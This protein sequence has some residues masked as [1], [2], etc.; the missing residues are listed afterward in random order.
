VAVEEKARERTGELQ[1]EQ[2][3]E[4]RRPGAIAVSADGEWIAFSVSAVC[5]SKGKRPESHIWTVEA[6]GTCRQAT[7][8]SGTDSLPSWSPDGTLAFASDREHAGR[9]SLYL[10]G[11]GPGEARP[12]GDVAGSVEDLSWSPDGRR[13]LVLAADLGADRAG[14]QAATKIQEAGAG[15]DDPKVKRP[16]ES[17]RRLYMVDAETGATEEVGPQGVHVFEVDWD[18]E[19]AVAICAD[20]PTESA[21]YK[22]HVALLDLE[23]RAADRLYE[24]EWQI[25]CPRLVGESV[26][27]VEG[28]CSDRGV[29]AG[30]VKV[31]D[32]GRRDVRHL[33]L[34]STDVSFMTRRDGERVWFAGMRGM[35]SVC[36]SLS[37]S[38]EVEE[39]W[40]GDAVLGARFQ[41]FVAAGG[42]RLVSVFESPERAPEVAELEDGHW[43]PLSDLNDAIAD[44]QQAGEWEARTWSADDGLEIEG[45]LLVPRSGEAPYPLIVEVHGGPTGA[46]SWSFLPAGFLGPLLA[47]EGYAV[48]LP[49]PRG[50][51]GRGQD[52]AR[53]NLRDMGGGD[54][55]DILAGVDALV[56]GELV[57]TRRVG[58]I[59][60]SY[61]GF[62]SAWAVTQTDRFAASIPL[63]AVTDWRSFHL[64]TNIGRFDELFLDADPYE[65]GG[66]YDARSPVVRAKSCKTPTLMVHGE[67]DLC[68]P[69]SQA[70]EM[71]QALIEAGS[72]TEL[73]LYPREGHGVLERDHQLDL[74][75]RVR[76]WFSRHLG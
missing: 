7:G 35:G 9:M 61:G 24:P 33:P 60:G 71:Y 3:L 46:W 38:G 18:G 25:Q 59:G 27:F 29:L 51:A 5:A 19:R 76:D 52:F 75:E 70:Q 30:D 2:L 4:L 64:T 32:L 68:V 63:A 67:E 50:S 47:Q 62:M 58:V 54:L 48:L 66:E 16:F 69:V 49:N 8:G 73:V 45:L 28:F 11:P 1:P 20:E 42:D 41:P 36:G 34:D 15:D 12:V 21:W 40:A 23:R 22:A 14:I 37:L 53:A 55:Q 65:V 39:I 17:W 57:D 72:E 43:R 10:L 31:L 13:L 26:C 56:D 74:W 6:D 44:P